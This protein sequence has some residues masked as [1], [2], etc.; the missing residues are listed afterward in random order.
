MTLLA[1]VALT[2]SSSSSERRGLIVTLVRSNRMGVLYQYYECYDREDSVYG[3][4]FNFE[5]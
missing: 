2:N 4:R 1:G 5:I 3:K